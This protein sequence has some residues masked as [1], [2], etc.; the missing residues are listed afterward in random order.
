V[1]GKGEIRLITN[2]LAPPASIS[3][4]ICSLEGEEAVKSPAR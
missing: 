1:T 3:C 4:M 2:T